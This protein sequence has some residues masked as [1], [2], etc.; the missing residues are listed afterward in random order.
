MTKKG[1][2]LKAILDLLE[3]LWEGHGLWGFDLTP[4]EYHF[5]KYDMIMGLVYNLKMAKAQNLATL[6]KNYLVNTF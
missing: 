6:S 1:C 2:P 5:R 4:L 3:P